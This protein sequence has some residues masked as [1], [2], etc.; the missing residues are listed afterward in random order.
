MFD[1][2][3]MDEVQVTCWARSALPNLRCCLFRDSEPVNPFTQPTFNASCP[4]RR[5]SR[6][7]THVFLGCFGRLQLNCHFIV[8]LETRYSFLTKTTSYVSFVTA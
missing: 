7:A 2:I 1:R 8:F 3:V 5:A 4:R 6:K